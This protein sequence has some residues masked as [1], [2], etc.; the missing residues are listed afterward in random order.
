M[1]EVVRASLIE[2]HMPMSY[3]GDALSSVAYLINRVP[4]SVVQFQTPFQALQDAT[5]A[6]IV[7][8]LQP[9]VFR[10][11]VFVHL[12]KHQRNKLEPRALRCVFLGYASHQKGYR[13]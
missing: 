1:L 9:H 8:N 6:P 2:A 12:H 7:P 13:R 11:V 5:N 3:W 4:S 10:C